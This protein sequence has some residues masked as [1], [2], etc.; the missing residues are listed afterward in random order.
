LLWGNAD[1]S[2]WTKLKLLDIDTSFE[3]VL[4]TS[5]NIY[6][7]AAPGRGLEKGLKRGLRSVQLPRAMNPQPTTEIVAP[8]VAMN[9]GYFAAATE[10]GT[11]HLAWLDGR[12]ERDHPIRSILTDTPS[13]EGNW[14]LYYRHRRDSDPTWSKEILLSKGLDFTFD[15]SMAAEGEHI[16]VV[17]GGYKRDGIRAVARLHPSDIFFTTSGDGGKTWKPVARITSN[18]TSGQTSI[19]PQVALHKG[20]IHLF[21][22]AGSLVYQRRAFPKD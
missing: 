18:A 15:P 16:V 7:L 10:G 8:T 3:Q 17:F 4:A 13:L 12:H 19:R 11:V 5:N 20:M 22:E 21:Y 9:G 14:E 1:G 2:R 6:F